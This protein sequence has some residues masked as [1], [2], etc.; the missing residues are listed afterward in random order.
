MFWVE[1]LWQVLDV[2]MLLVFVF[3]EEKDMF[4]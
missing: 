1:H 4:G 3:E 2:M